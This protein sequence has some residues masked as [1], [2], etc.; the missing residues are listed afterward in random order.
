VYQ[1]KN[2]GFFEITGASIISLFSNDFSL[3]FAHQALEPALNLFM[4]VFCFSKYSCS[5]L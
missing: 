2:F 5:L 1:K 4:R 3:D